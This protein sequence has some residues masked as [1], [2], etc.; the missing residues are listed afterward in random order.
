MKTLIICLTYQILTLS[1]Y[2]Q[3]D[4][5]SKS[6]LFD[7]LRQEP[8]SDTITY[9]DRIKP[10]SI[11]SFSKILKNNKI[12]A[13]EISTQK[14]VEFVLTRKEKKYLQKELKLLDEIKWADSI[15]NPSRMISLDKMWEYI[16]RRRREYSEIYTFKHSQSDTNY[17]NKQGWVQY[18]SIFQFSKPIFLRDNSIVIFYFLRLCGNECG[19]EDFSIYKKQDGQYK[20]WLRISGGVF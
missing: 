11:P 7:I 9:T 1:L 2:G 16:S 4:S 3:L 17:I 10:I 8:G 19:V 12:P 6:F 20:Q 18:C 14:K 5:T 15:F 13:F